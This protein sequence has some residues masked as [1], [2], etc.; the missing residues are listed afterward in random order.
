[1]TSPGGSLQRGKT[2]RLMEEASSCSQRRCFVD[3]SKAAA[4]EEELKVTDHRKDDSLGTS[5]LHLLLSLC[6]EG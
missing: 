1:M 4:G 5:Q 6:S 3:D 2:K